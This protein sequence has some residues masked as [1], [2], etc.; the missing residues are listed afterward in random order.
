MAMKTIIRRDGNAVIVTIEGHLDFEGTDTFRESLNR[1]ERQTA[2]SR[3]VFDLGQLQFVGSSG[4]S[5]FVQTLRDFNSRATLK[6]RYANVK[7]EFKKIILAFDEQ[8][9]FEFWD[10]TERALKS[11]DN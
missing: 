6:P 8:N 10:N 4:I 7:S 9:S 3:V 2:A 11:F 5:A 1:L